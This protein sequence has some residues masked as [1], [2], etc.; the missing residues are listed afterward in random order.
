MEDGAAALV[1]AQ[2]GEDV[3][4]ALRQA[5]GGAVEGDAEERRRGSH[6]IVCEFGGEGQRSSAGYRHPPEKLEWCGTGSVL[7][8]RPAS[9]GTGSDRGE[10][11]G[12]G[13]DSN[14]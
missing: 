9:K 3:A 5:D 11:L 2:C 14:R 12:D 10:D 1:K 6:F 4:R 13:E 8:L 7:R